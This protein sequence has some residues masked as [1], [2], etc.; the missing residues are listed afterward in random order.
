[1]KLVSAKSKCLYCFSD[2]LC[3]CPCEVSAS[4]RCILKTITLRIQSCE[5]FWFTWHRQIAN[6]PYLIVY[7]QTITRS[8]T[9]IRIS[10]S[11][12]RLF[13]NVNI[14][15]KYIDSTFCVVFVEAD[16]PSY[17]FLLTKK[18]PKAR[19]NCMTFIRIVH[20]HMFH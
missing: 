16:S 19:S 17:S 6:L 20:W 8:H 12:Y 3:L 11:S 7:T 13:T 5:W 10:S 1:M 2:N 9:Q 14:C 15:E 4:K 18:S